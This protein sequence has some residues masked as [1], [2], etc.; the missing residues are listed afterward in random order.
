MWLCTDATNDRENCSCKMCTPN[1]V[2]K[3][4]EEMAAY[5]AQKFGTGNTT[6]AP[7]TLQKAQSL[8]IQTK[9]GGKGTAT[10]QA[11]TIPNQAATRPMSGVQVVIPRLAEIRSDPD[12]QVLLKSEFAAERE[13]DAKPNKSI[14]RPGELVW[15]DKASAVGL[16]VIVSRNLVFQQPGSEGAEYSLQP[17]SHPFSYPPAVHKQDESKLKPWL[18]FT[19]PPYFHTYLRGKTVSYAEVNWRDVLTGKHGS[20]DAEADASMMAAKGIN[21]SYTLI[22]P[23]PADPTTMKAMYGGIYLGCEKVWVGEAVRLKNLGGRSIMIVSMI[24]DGA[25][26]VKI[27]GKVFSYQSGPV[28]QISAHPS[29]PVRVQDDLNYRNERSRKLGRASYWIP[30]GGQATV[31]LADITGRW[32]ESRRLIPIILGQDNFA[33]QHNSGNVGDVGDSLNARGQSANGAMVRAPDRLAAFGKSIPA[34]TKI[35]YI[36]PDAN[37]QRSSNAPKTNVPKATHMPAPAALNNAGNIGG[38]L[39]AAQANAGDISEFMDVDQMAH[40][41]DYQGYI[42]DSINLGNGGQF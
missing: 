9:D 38:G 1:D 24:S 7:T 28:G 42:G 19:V 10:K 41:H 14:F 11:I 15:Y 8:A 3:A 26:G 22:D 34:T 20:G 30:Q 25:E 32:Y 2:I 36:S 29:L 17:L 37:P 31:S 13:L 33:K 16:A 40:N 35:H 6:T 21:S 4:A 27:S 18:A 5:Q 23:L 12:P 39:V